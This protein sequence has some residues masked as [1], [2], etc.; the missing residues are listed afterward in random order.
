M[1]APVCDTDNGTCVACGSNGDCK[2]TAKPICDTQRGQNQCVQCVR[3][4]DCGS[5][6]PHCNNNVCGQ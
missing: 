5:A 6:A 1:D 2:D 4:M 3:D